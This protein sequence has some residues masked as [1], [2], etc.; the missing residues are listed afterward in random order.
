M[1]EFAASLEILRHMTACK[2]RERETERE[3]ETMKRGGGGR[4]GSWIWFVLNALSPKRYSQ[5]A[6]EDGDYTVTTRM[7]NHRFQM[8]SDG[9]HF[10]VS[11]AVRHKASHYTKCTTP[12]DKVTRQCPHR[13]QLLQR[14]ERTEA[15]SN[16]APSA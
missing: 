10:N 11:L 1:E 2:T 3:R 5:E 14:E 7:T 16:R 12:L 9:S 6:R 8:G 13:P 4:G 15:E